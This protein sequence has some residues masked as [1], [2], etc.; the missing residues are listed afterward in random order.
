MAYLRM[1]DSF[2]EIADAA[3]KIAFGVTK[4]HRPYEILE[5]V[6]EDSSEALDFIQ[7]TKDSQ[8]VGMTVKEAEY[9]DDF[10]QILAVRKKGKYF[11]FPKDDARINAGDS[12]LIKEYSSPEE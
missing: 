11:F 10:F 3:N 9:T 5:E 7:V 6:I 1:A 8:Y 4:R 12:L 2:E